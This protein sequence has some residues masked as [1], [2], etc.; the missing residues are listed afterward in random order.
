MYNSFPYNIF[1][2]T[3]ISSNNVEQ[4]PSQKHLEQQ[5]K[6]AEM[7]KAVSDYC[8]AAREIEP[9]YQQEAISACI[10]EVCRQMGMGGKSH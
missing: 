1:N 8:T 9:A 6:I 5:K 2:P 7:V 10:A 4:F 3:Y